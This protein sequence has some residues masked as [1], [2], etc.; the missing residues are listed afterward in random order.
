M[1]LPAFKIPKFTYRGYVLHLRRQDIRIQQLHALVFAGAITGLLAFLILY[2]DYGYFHDVY[3][4]KDIDSVVVEKTTEPVPAP[5]PTETISS[6]FSEAKT[7]FGEIGKS[8]SSL[9]Y[10]K[11]V[12]INNN[13]LK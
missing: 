6:F 13:T 9:L 11:D 1:K 5:S 12:Y 2:Y 10:G 4:Q 7:R 3:V 8:G